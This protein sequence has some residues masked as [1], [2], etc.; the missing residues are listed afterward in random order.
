MV[1]VSLIWLLL[2]LFSEIDPY[3]VFSFNIQARNVFQMGIQNNRIIIPSIF[4]AAKTGGQ[5][6]ISVISCLGI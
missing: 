1:I 6:F 5:C 4:F 2:E 3:R